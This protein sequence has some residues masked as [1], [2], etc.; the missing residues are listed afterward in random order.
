MYNLYTIAIVAF[1]IIVYRMIKF[2]K[3]ETSVII[4]YNEPVKYESDLAMYPVPPDASRSS[5]KFSVYYQK[6]LITGIYYNETQLTDEQLRPFALQ[7]KTV[8]GF[9]LIEEFD[10]RFE[11]Q[12]GFK[13]Y[14]SFYFSVSY[15][16]KNPFFNSL[17]SL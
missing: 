9:K 3:K 6:F 2:K 14:A 7:Y 5:F 11:F 8:R 15:D 4:I 17:S 1:V 13:K 12:F 16:P 10:C